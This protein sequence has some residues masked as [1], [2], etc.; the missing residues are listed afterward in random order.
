MTYDGL[1][2]ASEDLRLTALH[3][4]STN[5]VQCE[6]YLLLTTYKIWWVLPTRQTT[7]HLARLRSTTECAA[8]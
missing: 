5:T 1:R 3:L 6:S 4:C 8:D 7:F 2:P